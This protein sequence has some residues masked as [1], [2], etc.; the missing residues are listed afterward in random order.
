ML[1]VRQDQI[2]AELFTREASW[3]KAD[4]AMIDRLVVP[5]IGDIGPLSDLYRY[6]PLALRP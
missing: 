4:L 2:I 3:T 6:T 1:F 5:E